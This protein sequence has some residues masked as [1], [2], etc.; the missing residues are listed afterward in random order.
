[1]QPIDRLELLARIGSVLRSKALADEVRRHNFELAGKVVERTR[2]LEE[3]ASELR[4]ERD[5]LRET[6][7]VFDEALLLLDAAGKVQI[8]NAAGHKLLDET[9][10]GGRPGRGGARGPSTRMACAPGALRERAPAGRAGLPGPG[11]G[12]PCSTCAT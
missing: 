8:G 2:Q 5:T 1:V 7:D 9:Q 4:L 3:L 10:G 11:P 12:G 6:F